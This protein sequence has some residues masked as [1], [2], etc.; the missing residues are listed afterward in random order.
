MELAANALTTHAQVKEFL[1]IDAGDTSQDSIIKFLINGFSAF[2]EKYTGRIFGKVTGG[3]IVVTGRGLN[4][5]YLPYRNLS[6]IAS[7]TDSNGVVIAASGYSINNSLGVVTNL[8]GAWIDGESYTVV[9]TGGYVLPKDAADPTPVRDLP[10]DLELATV[11]MVARAFNK[12]DSEG[13]MSSSAGSMN[14]TWQ[15]ELDKETKA[16]LDSYRLIKI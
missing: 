9:L 4:K 13:A 10:F 11:K 12:K 1:S 8:S 14:V 2:A 6:S 16:I 7:I 5:L 15:T 3:S